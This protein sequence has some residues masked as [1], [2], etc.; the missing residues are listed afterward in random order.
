[1]SIYGI[2]VY[3]LSEEVYLDIVYVDS[4]VFLNLI[5]G[6]VFY[7]WLGRGCCIDDFFFGCFFYR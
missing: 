1:M 7:Y 4:F 5:F 2:C 3:S 6:T